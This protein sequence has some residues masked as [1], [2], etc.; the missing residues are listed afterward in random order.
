MLESYW[1]FQGHRPRQQQCA[2]QHKPWQLQGDLVGCSC[3]GERGVGHSTTIFVS[4]LQHEPGNQVLG[5]L[6]ALM[7]SYDMKM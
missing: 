7:S 1:L 3:T 5:I 6:F 4:S 2:W